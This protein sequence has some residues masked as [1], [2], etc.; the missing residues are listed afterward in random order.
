MRFLSSD[1]KCP[2]CFRS[3]RVRRSAR[4][5]L[6]FWLLI[7]WMRELSSCRRS[8]KVS[9]ST[10]ISNWSSWNSIVFSL[11][12]SR[13]HSTC[14]SVLC[15]KI[16][17]SR[18]NFSVMITF[19]ETLAKIIQ[20]WKLNFCRSGTFDVQ[21]TFP[22][23]F[24]AAFETVVWPWNECQCILETFHFPFCF[25]DLLIPKFAFAEIKILE[26]RTFPITFEVEIAYCFNHS[27]SCANLM[28][29]N[30]SEAPPAS[31]PLD[32][33]FITNSYLE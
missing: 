29:R 7:S 19:A 3:R 12:V 23:W 2:I 32:I 16:I 15:F 1:P 5:I 4:S 18:N 26:L 17:K 31:T 28:I 9:R 25:F 13:R 6:F 10:L 21:L 8:A 33:A 20:M 24:Q 30:A 11:E 22:S 27:R 14:R